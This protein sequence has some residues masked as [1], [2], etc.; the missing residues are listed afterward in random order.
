M[1]R[2]RATVTLSG[3]RAGA[4][5]ALAVGARLAASLV[6]ALAAVGAV[7]LVA[8]AQPARASSVSPSARTSG[9]R[10][11]MVLSREPVRPGW[12]PHWPAGPA[13]RRPPCGRPLDAIIA[14][15][16]AGAASDG[17]PPVRRLAQAERF[18]LVERVPKRLDEDLAGLLQYGVG[19]G[20]QAAEIGSGED[21]VEGH[22]CALLD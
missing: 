10:R 12:R 21:A 6:G 4:A 5:G 22:D 13:P 19:D 18:C 9:E 7:G 15:C 1:L 20:P 14:P 8:G 17:C 3:S 16:P 2:T 11:C